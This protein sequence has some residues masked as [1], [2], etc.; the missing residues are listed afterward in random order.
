MV[1]ATEQMNHHQGPAPPAVIILGGWS[2]GP[3]MYLQDFLASNQCRIIELEI[4]MPPIPG[5]W[6]WD[7]TV[8]GTVGILILMIFGLAYYAASDLHW[9][10]FAFIVFPLWFRFLASIV[11]RVSIQQ[12][13]QTALRAIRENE[14]RETILLGFSWGAAVSSHLRFITGSFAIPGGETSSWVVCLSWLPFSIRSLGDFGNDFSW[15]DWKVGPA[16]GPFDCSDDFLGR[17]GRQTEGCCLAN[18]TLLQFKKSVCSSWNRRSCLLSQ[19]GALAR[20]R[21]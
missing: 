6:C 18:T 3:L 2:P 7:R 15:N 14:G 10:L 16:I 13:I 12:G 9:F 5:S 20:Y 19:P 8:L 4:P 17:F 21:G 1:F 11:V